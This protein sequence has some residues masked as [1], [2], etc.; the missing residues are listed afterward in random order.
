VIRR[1][2]QSAGAQPASQDTI[3]GRAPIL[4]PTRRRSPNLAD[5]SAEAKQKDKKAALANPSAI[6]SEPR[7]MIIKNTDA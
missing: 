2:K 6:I 5:S 1:G 3:V 4:R 7:N